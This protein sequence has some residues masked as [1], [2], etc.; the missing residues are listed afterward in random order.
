ME[1]LHVIKVD[2]GNSVFCDLCNKDYTL[3]EDTGGFLFQSKAVCP[4]CSERFLETVK[5][6]NEERF[7]K[8][9][10]PDDMS[11]S[12]W[13]RSIREI[14]NLMNLWMRLLKKKYRK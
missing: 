1:K 2:P 14:N 4:D 11:F 8:G 12:D 7:I 6:Y 10:C 3:L 5:M 9:Y 13:I